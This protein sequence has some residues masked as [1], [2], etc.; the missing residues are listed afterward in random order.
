MSGEGIGAQSRQRE[1]A[2]LLLTMTSSSHMM[3]GTLLAS[4]PSGYALVYRMCSLYNVFSSF[5]MMRLASAPSGYAVRVEMELGGLAGGGREERERGAEER[6][7]KRGREREGE[8]GREARVRPVHIHLCI[9]RERVSECKCTRAHPP[10]QAHT[11]SCACTRMH[12]TSALAIPPHIHPH[13][14]RETK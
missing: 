1:K 10:T 7:V 11:Q 13:D 14:R 9:S 2:L 5:R 4:A 8:G 3:F 12:L 6:V